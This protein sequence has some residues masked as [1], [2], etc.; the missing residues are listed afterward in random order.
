[1]AVPPMLS[2]PACRRCTDPR[3]PERTCFEFYYYG[4]QNRC[5]GK[6]GSSKPATLSRPANARRPPPSCSSPARRPPTY[7]LTRTMQARTSSAGSLSGTAT[8]RSAVP[9]LV[10]VSAGPGGCRL[11]S[12]L[13]WTLALPLPLPLPL[14][15]A[16]G[17]ALSLARGVELQAAPQPR[18]AACAKLV[19]CRQV[20]A[21]P[22][23]P[24][25]L[26]PPAPA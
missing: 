13:A 9:I 22:A 17:V 6:L 4:K 12:T 1:M 5:C 24:L 26:P 15:T 3:P 11:H 10:A 23:A 16:P 2:V 21:P 7:S 14:A 20:L 8:P 18:P 19:M 25:H